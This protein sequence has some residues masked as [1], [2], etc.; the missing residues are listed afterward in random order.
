MMGLNNF[1]KKPMKLMFGLMK[2]F[3]AFTNHNGFFFFNLYS[4]VTFYFNYLDVQ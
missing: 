2:A 3:R 1:M 4:S